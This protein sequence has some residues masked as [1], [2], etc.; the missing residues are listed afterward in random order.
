MKFTQKID[1]YKKSIWW[2]N[3]NDQINCWL[4]TQWHHSY[5]PYAD[6]PRSASG[7]LESGSVSTGILVYIYIYI[8]HIYIYIYIYMCVCGSDNYGCLWIATSSPQK[9]WVICPCLSWGVGGDER[10]WL[11]YDR[12]ILGMIWIINDAFS[13][14]EFTC[15][16]P[17]N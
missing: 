6:P 16:E 8:L 5:G 15:W 1:L 14:V 12:G 9:A 13:T 7:G 3:G 4:A 10:S 2:K 17:G 11:S